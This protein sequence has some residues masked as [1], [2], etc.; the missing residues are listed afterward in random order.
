MSKKFITALTTVSF[1]ILLSFIQIFPVAA[2]EEQTSADDSL[3]VNLPQKTYVEAKGAVRKKFT[4]NRTS[5]KVASIYELNTIPSQPYVGFRK[6][7]ID[8]SYHNKEINWQAVKDSGVDFAILRTTYGWLEWENQT[9]AYLKEYITG[10]KAAGIPIGAYH[11]SYAKNRKDALLEADF[12]IDRLKWTQWEY[13]VF[14]DMEMQTQRNL[15][16]EQRTEVILTFANKLKK[17]GY[18][19]G[20]YTNLNW[21]R[22]MLNMNRLRAYDLWIAQ[23]NK[24]CH[25]THP[26]GIWQFTNQGIIPGIEGD[27]DMNLCYMDYPSI[28]KKAHLN[29]F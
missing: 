19:T 4:L 5:P 7:G 24:T 2:N 17:A 28:I 11:C 16:K 9:D 26:Y 8:V 15:T 22:H 21:T 14:I 20:Y 23:W 1:A 12:F 13:P 18:Y 10:A 3:K 27:V 29:G 6:V 25:C